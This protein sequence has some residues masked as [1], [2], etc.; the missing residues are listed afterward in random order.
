MGRGL[1]YTRLQRGKRINKVK[2]YV[3]HVGFKQGSLYK[4]HV[5]KIVQNGYGYFSM[6]GT[7]LHY[8]RGTKHKKKPIVID[9]YTEEV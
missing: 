6:S 9:Y 5:S 8:A 3:K 2:S 4:R 7:L 1:A